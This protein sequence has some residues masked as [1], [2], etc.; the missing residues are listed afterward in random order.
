MSTG[1]LGRPEASGPLELGVCVQSFPDVDSAQPAADAIIAST[2][3]SLLAWDCKLAAA[4]QRA[5]LPA[6]VESKYQ[7]L[8]L[9]RYRG[10]VYQ[11]FADLLENA[12]VQGSREELVRYKTLAQSVL[13]QLEEVN[14]AT[15]PLAYRIA[16]KPE[17]EFTPRIAD[18][19][20]QIIERID[21]P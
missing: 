7:Y 5:D 8:R 16:D 2:D 10:E 4:A 14:Q 17:L 19:M 3:L 15:S 6:M 20:N 11:D 21:T 12:C 1:S 13:S 18:R 9:S